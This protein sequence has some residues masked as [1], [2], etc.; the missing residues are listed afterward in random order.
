MSKNKSTII[1]YTMIVKYSIGNEW[2]SKNYT[3][4]AEA[5]LRCLDIS[6]PEGT[7]KEVI[8]KIQD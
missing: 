5:M 3:S 6:H 7:I 8:I 4:V 1:Y 2:H